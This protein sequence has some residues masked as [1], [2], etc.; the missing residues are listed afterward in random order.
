MKRIPSILGT[1]ADQLHDHVFT[2]VA[3]SGRVSAIDLVLIQLA[4]Q[5]RKLADLLG[6]AAQ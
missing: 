5:L 6:K 3:A 1:A 4:D 2:R